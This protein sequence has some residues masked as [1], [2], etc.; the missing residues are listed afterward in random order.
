MIMFAFYFSLVS[1][2]IM[3]LMRLALELMTKEKYISD[4]FNRVYPPETI[5]EDMANGLDVVSIKRR[6]YEDFGEKFDRTKEDLSKILNLCLFA[7]FAFWVISCIL[8]M[9]YLL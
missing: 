1:L 6:M 7:S 4:L 8:L 5:A 3:V 9:I 2:I